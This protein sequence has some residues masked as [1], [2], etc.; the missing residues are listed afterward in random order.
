MLATNP[1][2][3]FFYGLTGA[4]ALNVTSLSVFCL[5]NVKIIYIQNSGKN[6]TT[7]LAAARLIGCNTYSRACSSHGFGFQYP[8]Q[9]NSPPQCKAPRVS[10]AFT[11]FGDLCVWLREADFAIECEGSGAVEQQHYG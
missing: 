11:P 8:Q 7:F 4:E 3:R 5:W 1:V 10:G 9:K 6:R 2:A